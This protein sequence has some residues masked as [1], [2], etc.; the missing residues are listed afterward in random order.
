MIL[1]IRRSFFRRWPSTLIAKVVKIGSPQPASQKDEK[2]ESSCRTM[3]RSIN[4]VED[5]GTECLF[6]RNLIFLIF[7]DF[8]MRKFRCTIASILKQKKHCNVFCFSFGEIWWSD[9][10]RLFLH[11]YQKILPALFWWDIGGK[12]GFSLEDRGGQPQVSTEFLR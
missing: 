8:S 10:V 12:N 6:L 5:D 11:Q 2:R 7:S 4:K 3:L 1:E 9:W